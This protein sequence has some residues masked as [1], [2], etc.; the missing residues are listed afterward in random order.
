MGWWFLGYGWFGC[1]LGGREHAQ[2]ATPETASNNTSSI[3]SQD[4][5][6]RKGFE[7]ATAGV[8]DWLDF[9]VGRRFYSLFRS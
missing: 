8:S 5:L 3:Q 2:K 4:F 1:L 9:P 6:G 7:W